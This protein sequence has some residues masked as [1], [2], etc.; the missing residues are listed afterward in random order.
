MLE[1]ENEWPIGSDGL[2][3]RDAARVILIDE[4]D[5]IL[6]IQGHD[7]NNPA[8]QWWFTVGGGREEGET[9]REAAAR[10]C[11]EETGYSPDLSDLVGPV[12]YRDSKFYFADR[13]RRQKEYFFLARTANFKF[14]I[15]GWTADESKVLDDMRWISLAE[16]REIEQNGRIY[17]ALLPDLIEKW[18]KSG[19]DGICVKINEY[20]S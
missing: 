13:T 7:G 3:T 5:R 12:I 1:R 18:L 9:A 15:D 20:D 16:L 17:P 11:F 2:P 14:K 6:L 10:E 8:H 19:W 4:H